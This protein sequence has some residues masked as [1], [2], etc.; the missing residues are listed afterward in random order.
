MSFQR[1]S[2]ALIILIAVNLSLSFLHILAFPDPTW[3]LS[4]GERVNLPP[5]ASLTQT[6]TANRTNLRRVE[7]LFGKFTLQEEDWLT[8]ELRDGACSTLLAQTKFARRSF[9]SEHTYAFVF[10][11]IPDSRDQTYCLTI[12]F[13]SDRSVE[14]TK[15][16]RLFTD[17]S[18]Q[19]PPYAITEKDS[20]TPGN[21]PIA[22]R[23]GYVNASFVATLDELVDRISQYK[24]AF[25]KDGILIV[26]AIFGLGLT[27]MVPILLAH[28]KRVLEEEQK[29]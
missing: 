24:P 12:L 10:D 25:L 17:L 21:S 1:L 11:R 2:H 7:I 26:L 29:K 28:E 4:K 22:I 18:A 23:P 20:V 8:L 3:S 16:P 9:D 14:K 13:T 27:F 19:A 15:A 6:F 5:H